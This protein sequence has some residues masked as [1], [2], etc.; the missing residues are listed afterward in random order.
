MSGS[1]SHS[2]T[3][4]IAWAP[5]A[6]L[7][8]LG[9]ALRVSQLDQTLVADEM[10]SYVGATH[11]DLSQV[12]DWVQ[13]D[14]EIT[15]PLYT[16]LA[17]LSAMLGD[18]TVWVR[19]PAVVGGIL[20]IP[21]TYA[22]GRR[23]LR[24]QGAALLAAAIVTLSPFL[25]WYSVE[26]RAYGLMVALVAASTVSLLVAID[27][28]RWSWWALYAALSCA[29]MYTH[30]TAAFVL[31]AQLLW[32]AWFHPEVRVRL[33]VA[34]GAAAIAYIPW[35]S[36]LTDDLQS[37]TQDAIGAL[38]PFD[39]DSVVDFT[40]RFALGHPAIGL[41]GFLGS[42]A[43]A[44]I[45]CGLGLGLAGAFYSRWTG[46]RIGASFDAGSRTLWLVVLLALAT[47]VGAA[48]VSLTGDDLYLPRNLAASWPALAVVIAGLLSAGPP[49]I[50]AVATTLVIGALAYGALRTTE[51][52]LQ[53]PALKEA[54]AFIDENTGPEDVIVDVNPIGAGGRQGEPLTPP[55]LTLDI[56]LEEPH[57]MIDYVTPGDGRRALEATTPGRRVALVGNPLFVAAVA[58]QMRLAGPVDERLYPGIVPT[59]VQVFMV[60]ADSS[61]EELRPGAPQRSGAYY[62][63]AMDLDPALYWRLDEPGPEVAATDASYNDNDGLWA[64]VIEHEEPGA[65]DGND[66]VSL[67]PSQDPT[68]VRAYEYSPFAVDGQLTVVGLTRL[69]VL[70]RDEFQTLFGSDGPSN[71]NCTLEVNGQTVRWYSNVRSDYPV[72]ETDWLDAWPG[73]HKW[74][75]WA[76]TW[77]DSTIDAQLY[78]N[79]V[80]QKPSTEGLARATEFVGNEGRFQVGNRGD[81]AYEILD[82]L[83]DEIIVFER[84]LTPGE[85]T[86][87]FEAAEIASPRS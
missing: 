79:G 25:L 11:S 30:Y 55:A 7:V 81:G 24:N 14:E 42:W 36:G 23:T 22:L 27:R 1:T 87:L 4:V 31:L 19:L 34:N 16:V 73:A 43:E 68:Y 38:A 50:R 40:A 21:L 35:L 80:R 41:H 69:D 28:K 47:P 76:F 72:A 5:L 39:L 75:W 59:I 67:Q 77:D 57:R 45:I 9:A 18:P 70:V 61:D 83:M 53:R 3:G 10:W 56:N 64:G 15:P 52:E 48:L 33:F 78:I 85:L 44:A 20:T 17:W 12:V 60:T 32:A 46:R 62:R 84:V 58:Q 74:V 66:S 8:V 13:S 29:A 51:A 65:V 54:A 63:T 6:A 37:P 86:S 2:S 71:D 49:G 82:G 26:A